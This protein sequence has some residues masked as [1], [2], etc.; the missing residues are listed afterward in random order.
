MVV[1]SEPLR[2][3]DGQINIAAL[4]GHQPGQNASGFGP[5][6][7]ANM[8]MPEPGQY[9]AMANLS[10]QRQ[11]V[12]RGRAMAQPAVHIFEPE[13]RKAFLDLAPEQIKRRL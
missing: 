4:S 12:G 2:I 6:G 11:A 10:D 8:M 5:G 3:V 9:A 1:S 13:V 7:Q